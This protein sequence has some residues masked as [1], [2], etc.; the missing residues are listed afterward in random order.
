MRLPGKLLNPN[1]MIR[2]DGPSSEDVFCRE[3]TLS[4]RLTPV[5]SKSVSSLMRN[6]SS[7]LYLTVRWLTSKLYSVYPNNDT[8]LILWA[9]FFVI[10]TRT[11]IIPL[12][13][14]LSL[15]FSLTL[16]VQLFGIDSW[17][18]R[19][20]SARREL[21]QRFVLGEIRRLMLY[22]NSEDSEVFLL[23]TGITTVNSDSSCIS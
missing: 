1:S 3:S 14:S 13:A 17:I 4:S 23:T 22:D 7:I 21:L 19:F 2:L 9:V 20:S 12:I 10:V 15:Y 8:C 16:I 6:S 5:I 11:A 18:E